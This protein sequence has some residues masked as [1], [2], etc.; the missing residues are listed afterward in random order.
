MTLGALASLHGLRATKR[1]RLR[2]IVFLALVTI[3]ALKSGS[4][5]SSLTIFVFCGT[6][7]VIALI[8]RGVPPA[9]SPLA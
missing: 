9:F 4:A 5:T 3:V 6:D 7:A 1:R 2:N 8:R